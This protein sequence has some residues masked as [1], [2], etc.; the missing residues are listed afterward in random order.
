LGST[1]WFT[2]R[3]PSA[4]ATAPKAAQPPKS[5]VR[6]G[7]LLL[8]EDNLVNRE[9]A[10]TILERA[11]HLV[12]VVADGDQAVRAVKASQ[13]DA[14]LMD[15]QMP[16][17]DGLAATRAIRC[18][19]APA[20]QVP[21]I[22][23]SADV[24]PDHVRRCGEAGM[25]D[26]VGK[27]FNPDSLLD[28]LARWL[29]CDASRELSNGVGF[30]ARIFEVVASRVGATRMRELLT[31]LDADLARAFDEPIDSATERSRLRFEA[32]A[33][34]SAASVLGFTAVMHACCELEKLDEAHVTE[35]GSA[36][37]LS[38]VAK[39]RGAANAARAEIRRRQG[40]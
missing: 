30:D 27:P 13:F 16:G 8:V 39:A 23:M 36:P 19:P 21:V 32:H 35:A 14:V 18:L 24:L 5:A 38:A 25:N 11:G 6:S 22:G 37:F 10:R 2:V 31:I 4:E 34:G 20:G 17:M 15:V 7:R 33:L 1:F 40:T 12:E 29:P 26:H 3:L 28:I 9:L